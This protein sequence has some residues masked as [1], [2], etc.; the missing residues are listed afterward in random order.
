MKSKVLG[1]TI[2][3]AVIAAGI[4][5]ALAM[6]HASPGGAQSAPLPSMG[7]SLGLPSQLVKKLDFEGVTAQVVQNPPAG[8]VSSSSVEQTFTSGMGPATFDETYLVQ[9]VDSNSG[10][11]CTCWLLVYTPQTPHYSEGGVQATWYAVMYDAFTGG[12]V[13][14]WE[15]AL[16][17]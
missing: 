13:K 4:S 16:P 17:V 1:I 14:G 2:P 7:T 12:F 10:K 3:T 15:G 11:A 9:A 5:V 8:T 6:S